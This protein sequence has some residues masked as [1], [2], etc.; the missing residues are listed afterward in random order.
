MKAV[1]EFVPGM[2]AIAQRCCKEWQ[3]KGRVK[4]YD[5]SKEYTFLVGPQPP[6]GS[7]K[8]YQCCAA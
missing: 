2:V 1:A 5:C 8:H 3:E 4:A 6:A 7:L